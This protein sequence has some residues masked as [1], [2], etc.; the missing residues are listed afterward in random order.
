MIFSIS[1]GECAGT[2]VLVQ[3]VY[4]I[5]FFYYIVLEVGGCDVRCAFSRSDIV[6]IG[7]GF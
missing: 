2:E 6:S 3:S 1:D 7:T 5:H 4:N